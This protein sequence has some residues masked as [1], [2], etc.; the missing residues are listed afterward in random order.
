MMFLPSIFGR[1]GCA[2]RW[3]AALI[4]NL[5]PAGSAAANPRSARS[6]QF[7]GAICKFCLALP[8]IRTAKSVGSPD[9]KSN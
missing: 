5:S 1:L 9:I 8:K 2:R 6:G 3:R 4:T 7:A